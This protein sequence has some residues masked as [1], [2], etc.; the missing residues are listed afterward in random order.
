MQIV[1]LALGSRGDVQPFIALGLGLQAAGYDVRIVATTDYAE[2]VRHYGLEF[3]SA[4]GSI[5]ELMDPEVVY[6]A[7]DHATNPLQFGLRFWQE[8][9]PLIARITS[10]CWQASHDADV[11][12]VSTLGVYCGYDIAERLDIPLVEAHMH[13]YGATGALPHVFFPPLPLPRPL[14]RQY[15]RW[16]HELVEIAFWQVLHTALNEARRSLLDL[17]A[18][19]R[20]AALRQGLRPAALI[21]HAYSPL[22]APKPADWSEHIHITGFWTL[23]QDTDW[24]PPPDL[25]TFLAAGAPPV[26][27]GFGSN[28]VGRDPDHITH[29][30][31]DALEK[32][33][34]RGLLYAGWGDF[35]AGPLPSSVLRIN[36]VPHNWLFQRVSA[37]VHHGGAGTTAA[38]LR[39]GTPSI[40]IPFFGDQQLWA[41]QVHRLGAAPEPLPHSE[42]ST[43]RLSAALGATLDNPYMRRR[44]LAVGSTLRAESGVERAVILL[45][46]LL[47]RV[48]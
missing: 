38:T 3:A 5:R 47:D 45:R 13:P 9:R 46:S 14:R 27:I 42:L 36:A 17:P 24:Q 21:L 8:I 35:G 31:V 44:A 10:A 16:T 26:Y 20:R 39:A 43:A 29:I 33:N 2:L 30:V 15:N 1:M 18:L 32:Q 6:A 22:L 28:L 37:V 19:S 34:Q 4:G 41:R 25:A 40:F 23:P 12:I 11:L 48:G 7:F